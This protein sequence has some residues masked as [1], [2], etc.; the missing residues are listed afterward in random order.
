MMRIIEKGLLQ[1]FG[2]DAPQWWVTRLAVAKSLQIATPPEE[3]EYAPP[4]YTPGGSELHLDQVTGRDKGPKDDYT[5]A[6]MLLLS[7]RHKVDYFRDQ[8]A[9]E[10]TLHRHIRR[11]LQ[12]IKLSWRENFDFFDYLYQDLFFDRTDAESES[13]TIEGVESEHLISALQKLNIRAEVEQRQEGLRLTRFRLLLVGVEDYER[14]RRNIDDLNFILGLSANSIT[15]ALGGGERRVLLE[16]PRPLGTWRYV[17]WPD[18]KTDLE[19]S[20]HALPVCVSTDVLGAPIWFD[21]ASAPHLL[22]GGTTGSGKSICVHAVILSLLG[23]AEAPELLLIDAKAVELTAYQDYKRLARGGVVTDMF[24]AAEALNE[25]AE[26]MEGRQRDY[27]ALGARDFAEARE[28]GSRDRR[29]VV[30]VDELADLVLG[31]QEVVSPLVRLAQKARAFGIHLVL[32]TQRPEAGTFPG[33]LRSN[34]PSRIAMTVQKNAE[35]RIILDEGGA[36]NMLMRGDMLMRLAG[37]K[38][39]RAHG[40]LVSKSDITQALAEHG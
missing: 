14:L 12:E 31:N 17:T 30:I 24:D 20:S 3:D 15:F 39:T 11:G 26:R 28:R 1:K 19:S 38:T 32:A 25:L 23:C 36:E 6:L 34:L 27:L 22:I 13:T 5:S 9:F 29:I 33:L 8:E 37:E 21:L 16:V 2:R 10:E 35:S 7:V 18:I 40:I 4:P